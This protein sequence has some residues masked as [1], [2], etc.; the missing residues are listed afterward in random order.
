M[1]LLLM[2][3]G[4]AEPP[5]RTDFDR[6]LTES[7]RRR[8]ADASF[9]LKHI[10]SPK[11]VFIW[12]SPLPRAKQTAAIL[13]ETLGVANISEHQEIYSGELESLMPAILELP[14]DS[15]LVIVGHEPCLSG[16]SERIS[17]ILIPFKPG[18]AACYKLSR[19]QPLSGKL[20]WFAHA[21]IL[22]KW[23]I[24]FKPEGAIKCTEQ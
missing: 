21:K 24:S 8:I 19:S 11:Q 1:D 20:R 16:W 18:A 15:V 4:K 7:G 9:G 2:R 5:H 6:E 10:L 14:E 22:S 3:H 23:G 13:A 17:G 12:A